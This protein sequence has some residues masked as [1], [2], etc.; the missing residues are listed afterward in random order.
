MKT[1]KKR[2][3]FAAA[4]AL[5]TAVT[6]YSHDYWFEPETFFAPAGGSD[7]GHLNSLL[8]RMLSPL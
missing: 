6:V 7:S 3:M 4:A 5:L 2:A 1:M 8:S